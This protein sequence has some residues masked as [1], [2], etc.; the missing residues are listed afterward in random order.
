[1]NR[2]LTRFPGRCRALLARISDYPFDSVATLARRNS[3]KTAARK[4]CPPEGR[5]KSLRSLTAP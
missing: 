3:D 5:A 1:M 2:Q 4:K